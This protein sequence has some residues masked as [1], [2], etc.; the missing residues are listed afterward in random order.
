MQHKHA[1]VEKT[2]TFNSLALAAKFHAYQDIVVI[3]VECF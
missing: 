1:V 2:G 3:S